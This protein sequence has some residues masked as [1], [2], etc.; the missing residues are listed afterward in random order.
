MELAL[1]P[2]H[3]L[4]PLRRVAAVAAQHAAAVDTVA[5]L[6]D[7]EKILNVSQGIVFFVFVRKRH[8]ADEGNIFLQGASVLIRQRRPLAK[9]WLRSLANELSLKLTF[10]ASDI[11][12]GNNRERGHF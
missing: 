7:E 4:L 6:K 11:A 5:V 8:L 2:L 3:P 12:K 10:S 1:A 9:V